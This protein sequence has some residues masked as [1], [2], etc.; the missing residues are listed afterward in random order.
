MLCIVFT[1]DKL[2]KKRIITVSYRIVKN[3][4]TGLKSYF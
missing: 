3:Q 2:K 1:F 4:M